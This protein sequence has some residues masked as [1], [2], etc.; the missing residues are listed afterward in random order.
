MVYNSLNKKSSGSDAKS[1]II[2]DQ[3][4]QTN[5]LLENLKN[6]KYTHLLKKLLRVLIYQISN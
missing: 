4:L 2:P 3:Q 5:H 1:E 6:E